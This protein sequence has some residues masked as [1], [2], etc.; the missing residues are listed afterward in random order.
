[1]LNQAAL[2][3]QARK[4]VEDGDYIFGKTIA[5]S[6]RQIK[7]KRIKEYTKLTI[8]EVICYAHC[9]QEALSRLRESP[10]PPVQN[11]HMHI[12]SIGSHT[13]GINCP[14]VLW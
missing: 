1:M 6:L 14:R 3:S 11:R 7:N 4:R 8:Q 5:F 9:Q 12:L 10:I 13:S 2:V